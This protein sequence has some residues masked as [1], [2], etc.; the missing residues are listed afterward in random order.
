L[1]TH[2]PDSAL[3]SLVPPYLDALRTTNEAIACP[4]CGSDDF[5]PIYDGIAL[6]GN[7]L[8]CV[9]CNRCTHFFLNPRPRLDAFKAFYAG[10]NYF[11]L[12]AEFSHVSL[13]EKLAEFGSEEFWK[14]RFGYGARLYSTYF[15]DVLGPGDL[16]FDFGC[17]DGAWLWALRELSG[18][19]IDGEEISDV[20]VDVIKERLG[21]DVFLGG[22][23]ETADAIVQ[24]HRG[25]AKAAI[26]SGSLQHMLD[27]M[28]C[29]RVAHEILRDDGIFYVCNWSIFEHYM[30]P[31]QGDP[32][33]VYGAT[34]RVL[35]E[36]LSWEHLHYFHET[37][38]RY[39][40]E[41]AGFEIVAFQ[42]E[43]KVRP[44]HM[45]ALCRKASS[46]AQAVPRRTA[47]NVVSRLRALES[48][49]VGRRVSDRLR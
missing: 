22:I 43:S 46:P 32:D 36:V 24:K 45:D 34:Q 11:H 14:E 48:A 38:F 13:S 44:R 28:K 30:A 8:T 37:S 3:D 17:G 7:E 6:R 40:L 23:E 9:I 2:E 27:P 20:Y 41:S 39:M 5:D 18:C 4:I 42:L 1:S 21:I 31:Y 19:S 15:R 10:A 25:R 26:V 12:C 29:L 49:T 33:R 35:G 16:A 47:R